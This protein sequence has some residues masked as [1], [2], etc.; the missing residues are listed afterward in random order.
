MIA[1]TYRIILAPTAK[2][3]LAGILDQRILEKIRARIDGL[4]LSPELQGKPMGEDLQGYRSLRAVGQRYRIL[5]KVHRSEVVVNV[6]AIGL[7]KEGD[8]RDI[9]VLAAKLLRLGLL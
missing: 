5:Y 1:T 9:Y 6:V 2:T 8:K 7:R 4:A 3:M